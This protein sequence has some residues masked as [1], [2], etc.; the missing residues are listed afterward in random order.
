MLAHPLFILELSL[1]LQSLEVFPE[2]VSHDLF[3]ALRGMLRPLLSSHSKVVLVFEPPIGFRAWAGVPSPHLARYVAKHGGAGAEWL[4]GVP[5]TVGGALAMNAGCY[6]GETWNHV[7]RVQTVDR[8]GVLHERT[9]DDYELGYRHVQYRGHE[10]E[11]FV[12][13]RFA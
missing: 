1:V 12:S 11:W 2:Y 9:P 5:G 7:V 3:G 6:G 13:G 4:A 10:E 8:A